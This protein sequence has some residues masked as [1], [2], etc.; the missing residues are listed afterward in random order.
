MMV[1]T[2][3]L[4]TE[5]AELSSESFET[6]CED[7]SS[8]FG[9]E[10]QSK[11][12][13]EPSEE[14]IIDLK[15]HFKKISAFNAVKT[16]GKLDGKFYLVF[17][18]GG[19]FTLSGVIVMMP[20]KRI[21]EEIKKG[22][23]Q[24]IKSMTDAIKETGNLAV[25]S[26]DRI[27]RENYTGHGHFVQGDVYIGTPWGNTKEALDIESDEEIIFIPYEI[28]ISPFPVFNCGVIFPKALFEEKAPIETEAEPENQE[29]NN[30][31]Q[32]EQTTE[33]NLVQ[34][35]ET[36][37]I[38]P[39][40]ENITVSKESEV[41]DGELPGED[42]K[43]AEPVQSD[44]AVQQ[45][46]QEPSHQEES[47]APKQVEPTK[48]SMSIQEITQSPASLPG[49]KSSFALN[50]AAK[51]IMR[52]NIIWCSSDD[53]VQQALIKMQEHNTRYLIIGEESRGMEGI[54]SKSDLDAALSPYLR[55]IFSKWRRTL[56]DATLKI[57]LKWIMNNPVYFIKPQTP[58]VAII[59]KMKSSARLCLPVVEDNKV[60]GLITVSDIFSVILDSC[61][62]EYKNLCDEI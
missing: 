35:N 59:Q 47:E 44:V 42:Q 55:P 5:L 53:C 37:E 20:E 58:I 54:I 11:Q 28:T 41:Q 18:Q 2:T 39:E 25:G 51:D 34:E 9:V 33:E 50:I 56:D 60:L 8:M 26:W 45:P 52:G 14:K 24:D 7:I 23:I 48:I 62:A 17:D 40:A 38:V 22:L 57:K 29:Q 3:E 15:K 12:T 32:Q 16:E 13:G 19:T 61:P 27:F 10:M 36:T 30:E 6:F 46:E 49:E 1:V 21:L 43:T 31:E 4:K